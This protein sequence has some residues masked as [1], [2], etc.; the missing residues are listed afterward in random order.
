MHGFFSPKTRVAR[1]DYFE[2]IKEVSELIRPGLSEKATLSTDRQ[3]PCPADDL[4]KLA[5]IMM[6]QRGSFPRTI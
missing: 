2:T 4:H 1:Q 6:L 5:A 3:M